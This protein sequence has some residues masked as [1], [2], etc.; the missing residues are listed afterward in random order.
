MTEHLFVITGGP[1]SGKSSLVEA[2]A[3]CGLQHMPEAGRA[4]IQDQVSIGG[5]ALP[6]SD[7]QAFAELMLAWE[8]RSHHEASTMRGPVICDRG[9]PD[10]VGYLTLCELPVPAHVERAAELFR[11]NRTVFI[12]PHW[13][14]IF[15]QDAQR[16]Q[17]E[18]EAAATYRIMA[19]TY[20]RLGYQL[21]TL[22][23]VSIEERVSFIQARIA[24]GNGPL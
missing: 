9:V 11:Y 16:K 1:G 3:R 5:N 2:L 8:L 12:A 14:A 24:S 21:V 22:P 4:I 13:P 7:R 19:D 15:S 18:A 20:S 17:S 10:V 6:W 23:L